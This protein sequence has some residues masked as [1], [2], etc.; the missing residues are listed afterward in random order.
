MGQKTITLVEPYRIASEN[1]LGPK[2]GGDR[3]FLGCAQKPG[4]PDCST[5]L[6]EAPTM[7]DAAAAF[8]AW[9]Q[10]NNM[11]SIDMSGDDE[12]KF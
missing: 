8:G 3:I 2:V 6:I 7:E 5:I 4:Q 11:E 9:L 10:V 1:M 12:E